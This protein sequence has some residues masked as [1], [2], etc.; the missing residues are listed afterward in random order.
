MPEPVRNL[1]KTGPIELNEV[2]EK[3]K[4]LATTDQD[5]NDVSVDSNETLKNEND[6]DK[7]RNDDDSSG[8]G[9]PLFV[10]QRSGNV[11]RSYKD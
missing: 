4:V 2:V 11:A 9:L 5:T 7:S 8:E 3:L 10:F 6:E 1:N